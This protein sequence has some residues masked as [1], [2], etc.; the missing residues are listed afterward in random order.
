MAAITIRNVSRSVVDSLKQSAARNGHSM[1]E[2]ARQ[3]LARAAGEP[4][5]KAAAFQ[6][7]K[8]L[9]DEIGPSR[10]PKHAA[11]IR[12]ERKKRTEKL[13]PKLKP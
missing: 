2:E 10:G 3:I 4:Q 11:L 9:S 5:D 1:E 7:I 12:Q 13:A 8:M 6:H